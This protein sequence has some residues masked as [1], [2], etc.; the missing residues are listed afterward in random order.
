MFLCGAGFQ[1]E[2]A[3]TG[4]VIQ[5]EGM[6][7]PNLIGGAKM[8]LYERSGQGATAPRLSRS[9]SRG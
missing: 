1:V 2:V 6:T 4:R 8:S 9:D 3:D 7:V 5:S